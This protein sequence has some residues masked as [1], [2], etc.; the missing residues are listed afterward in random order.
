M[1]E[2]FMN[3]ENEYRMAWLKEW[4]LK[5]KSFYYRVVTFMHKVPPFKYYFCTLQ[6]F[7][8]EEVYKKKLKIQREITA[9]ISRSTRKVLWQQAED[10]FIQAE[11]RL[12]KEAV[13]NISKKFE[14]AE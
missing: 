14:C 9:R 1:K 2:E 10:E 4:Q 6:Y 12:I 13:E 5:L 7:Q 3:S 11:L 8:I